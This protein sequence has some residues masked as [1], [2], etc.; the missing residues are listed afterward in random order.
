MEAKEA[1]IAI[2]QGGHLAGR[3]MAP[4]FRGELRGIQR[5]P[6]FFE[7]HAEMAEQQPGA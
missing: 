6:D 7:G 4:D 1:D 2:V 3:G 5:Q